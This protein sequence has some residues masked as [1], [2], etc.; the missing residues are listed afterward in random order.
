ME[1][2]ETE[3]GKPLLLDGGYEYVRDK[4]GANGKVI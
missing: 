1:F 2:T 4:D 3:K